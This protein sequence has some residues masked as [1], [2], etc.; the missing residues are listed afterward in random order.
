MF[1][2]STCRSL[3]YIQLC[4]IC[5]KYYSLYGCLQFLLVFLQLP[6]LSYFRF[7]LTPLISYCLCFLIIVHFSVCTTMNT[8]FA[9]L[10]S[11]VQALVCFTVMASM[12]YQVWFLR[13]NMSQTKFCPPSPP[14]PRRIN[15]TY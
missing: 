7:S 2:V 9:H 10:H 15:H 13:Q 1:V 12:S 11:H 14:R 8:S 5:L 3:R 4:P 6:N